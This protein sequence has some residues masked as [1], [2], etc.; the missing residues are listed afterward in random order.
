MLVEAD[1]AL[2]GLETF[3][4]CQP[5][6]GLVGAQDTDREADP[7]RLGH[8]QDVPHTPGLQVAAQAAADPA[9]SMARFL[10][11]SATGAQLAWRVK[12]SNQHLPGKG[13]RHPARR[14]AAGATPRV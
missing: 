3:L 5:S 6:D 12:N 13:G 8:R 1:L 2:A 11:C 14:V 4:D 7:V 10:A 9:F